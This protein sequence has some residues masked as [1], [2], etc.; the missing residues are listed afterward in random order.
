[1]WTGLV[2]RLELLSYNFNIVMLII[3]IT[4]IT[5]INVIITIIFYR[6]R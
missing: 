2:G 1:M 4:T 3:L 5:N 6:Q